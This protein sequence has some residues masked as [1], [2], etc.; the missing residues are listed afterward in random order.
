[1]GDRYKKKA[2]E[3]C[4]ILLGNTQLPSIPKKIT[5]PDLMQALTGNDIRQC[6]CCKRKT[7]RVIQAILPEYQRRQVRLNWWDTS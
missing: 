6:P 3:R 5:I 4:R 7:L 1:L 2:L